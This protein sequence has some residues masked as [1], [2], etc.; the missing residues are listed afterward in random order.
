MS[1]LFAV[2]LESQHTVVEDVEIETETT[3]GKTPTTDDGVS[4]TVLAHQPFTGLGHPRSFCTVSKIGWSTL[5]PGARPPTPFLARNRSTCQEWV[6]T[7]QN[8]CGP[9]PSNR[10]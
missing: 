2:G 5:T 8:R 10:F 6:T 1:R 4:D 7:Y 9:V 3:H